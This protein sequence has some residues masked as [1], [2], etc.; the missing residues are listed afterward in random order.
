MFSSA[1]E[2]T[3]GEDIAMNKLLILL[4]VLLIMFAVVGPVAA[5]PAG[6]FPGNFPG[7]GNGATGGD[8]P[9]WSQVNPG[10][11]GT[12]PPGPGDG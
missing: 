12:M 5:E 7:V 10:Q 2:R 4:L 11:G 9:G 1:K 3:K 6:E 8:P